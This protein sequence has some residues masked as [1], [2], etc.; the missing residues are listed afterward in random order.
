MSLIGRSTCVSASALSLEA[1]PA[2]VER[3]V[4]RISRPVLGIG[5]FFLNQKD[6]QPVSLV[7]GHYL[8]NYESLNYGVVVVVVGVSGEPGN[9]KMNWLPLGTK[10]VCTP[11]ASFKMY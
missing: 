3:V 8:T 11:G 1:Q 10:I 7:A 9:G 4:R 2:H 6:Q 5:I